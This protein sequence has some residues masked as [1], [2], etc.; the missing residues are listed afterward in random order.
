MKTNNIELAQAAFLWLSGQKH[1]GFDRSELPQIPHEKIDYVIDTLGLD[2][3]RLRAKDLKP[4]QTQLKKPKV[5][6]KIDT[7]QQSRRYIVSK[8]NYLID[9]HHSWAGLIP[10]NHLL[11]CYRSPDMEV[12]EMVDLLTGD[13]GFGS[14]SI[15]E[16]EQEYCET[17]DEL[18]EPEYC[19]ATYQ[20]ILKLYRGVQDYDKNRAKSL[21]M[22]MGKRYDESVKCF[23]K[24]AP[25]ATLQR[26]VFELGNLRQK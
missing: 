16:S 21:I 1:G 24:R 4:S 3:I 18:K 25:L 12:D 20:R 14:K 6:D 8:D 2:H 22:F 9:G 13:M 5:L 11:N 17:C 10:E 19:S 26:L 23:C 15:N 7:G